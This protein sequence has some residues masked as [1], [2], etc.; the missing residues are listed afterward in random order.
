MPNFSVWGFGSYMLFAVG[1]TAGVA[2]FTE[3]M[4]RIESLIANIRNGA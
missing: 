2:L 1:L 3:P 4:S